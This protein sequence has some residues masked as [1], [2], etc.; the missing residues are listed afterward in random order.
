M[1]QQRSTTF[2]SVSASASRNS[3]QFHCP[4]TATVRE[5]AKLA[6]R[7]SAGTR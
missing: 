4:G 7:V 6:S 2:A 1:F 5:S 3:V